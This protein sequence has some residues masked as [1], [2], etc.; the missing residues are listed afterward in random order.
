MRQA[1]ATAAARSSWRSSVTSTSSAPA[2]L[3]ANSVPTQSLESLIADET[4][5]TRGRR[6]TADANIPSS[7]TISRSGLSTWLRRG[8]GQSRPPTPT[9]PDE[10]SSTRRFFTSTTPSASTRAPSPSPPLP[11]AAHA[12]IAAATAT[13]TSVGRPD[14]EL[15]RNV[16]IPVHYRARAAYATEGNLLVDGKPTLML[17]VGDRV[18]VLW[19]EDDG[20]VFARSEKRCVLPFS[21]LL[22]NTLM[23]EYSGLEGYVRAEALSVVRGLPPGAGK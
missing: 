4:Y 11:A 10:L 19:Q 21:S 1:E 17:M 14:F 23:G 20:W 7:P 22:I 13:A 18:G 8:H 5:G 16:S 2:A 3:R 12:I 15:E 9:T 6:A